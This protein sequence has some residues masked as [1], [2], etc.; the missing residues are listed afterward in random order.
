M[1]SP[2]HHA[3]LLL[4]YIF[5]YL[6]SIPNYTLRIFRHTIGAL[7][8]TR[9]KAESHSTPNG[10]LLQRKSH[11]I[12]SRERCVSALRVLFT[13]K[14]HSFIASFRCSKHHRSKSRVHHT[15]HTCLSTVIFSRS[16]LV[17]IDRDVLFRSL[18]E[19]V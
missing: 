13:F 12:S 15:T 7:R 17:T 8:C 18:S 10:S 3:L 2:L 16:V 19:R 14:Y 5:C 6:L 1:W 9:N 11:A 4:Q